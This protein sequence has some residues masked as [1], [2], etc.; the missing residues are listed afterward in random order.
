MCRT[1]SRGSIHL[2]Y[3]KNFLVVR[4]IKLGLRRHV[5]TTG[6]PI[7]CPWTQKNGMVVRPLGLLPD[8]ECFSVARNIFDS[9]AFVVQG[10]MHL[11]CQ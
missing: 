1:M 11:I 9:L 7:W 4:R 8:R 2:H 3:L 5:A 10:R 6:T